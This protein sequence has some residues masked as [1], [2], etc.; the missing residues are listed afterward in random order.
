MAKNR[1]LNK[2][3]T[4][5]F[6]NADKILKPKY[7]GGIVSIIFKIIPM[8]TRKKGIRNTDIHFT[9]LADKKSNL[10]IKTQ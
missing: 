6:V 3:I 2:N 10:P 5:R 1:I 9:N 7:R 4:A 8:P